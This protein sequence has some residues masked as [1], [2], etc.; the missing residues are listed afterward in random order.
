MQLD[1]TTGVPT[2]RPT[3]P[4]LIAAQAQQVVSYKDPRLVSPSSPQS[5]SYYRLPFTAHTIQHL[6]VVQVYTTPLHCINN[7]PSSSS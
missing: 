7:L 2:L 5:G 3:H 1:V 4:S 6:Y